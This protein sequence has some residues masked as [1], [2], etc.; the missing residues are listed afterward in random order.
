MQAAQQTKENDAAN[1]R[2]AVRDT[3]AT[4]EKKPV[5]LR[6]QSDSMLAVEAGGRP[7][8][9][10]SAADLSDLRGQLRQLVQSL[11][12]GS[13]GLSL[14]Q[15]KDRVADLRERIAAAEAV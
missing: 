8:T 2:G 15:V 10:A 9:A 14:A 11:R 4:G 1:V 6:A 7:P 3:S 12:S 13:S 5:A